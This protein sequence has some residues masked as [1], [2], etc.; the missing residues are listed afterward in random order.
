M[1][2]EVREAELIRTAGFRGR[3]PSEPEEV[4]AMREAE[5]GLRGMERGPELVG[6]TVSRSLLKRLELQGAIP[7]LAPEDVRRRMAERMHRWRTEVERFVEGENSIERADRLRLFHV[8]LYPDEKPDARSGCAC[9]GT[10]LVQREG[11]LVD[12]FGRVHPRTTWVE[13]C[14]CRY[15]LET[16]EREV[17]DLDRLEDIF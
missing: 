6:Q 4:V 17:E 12:K 13:P 14:F 2:D 8:E 9:D 10:G 1:G 16:R 11:D 15:G 7:K 5:A 3:A